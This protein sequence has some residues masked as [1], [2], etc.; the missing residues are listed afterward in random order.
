MARGAP[1][2]VAALLAAMCADAQVAA[3]QW[4]SWR[5]GPQNAGAR[6]CPTPEG[7]V[8]WTADLGAW[9]FATPVIDAHGVVYAGSY[10]GEVCALDGATGKRRW[11]IA[12]GAP[13]VG[14]LALANGVV[15]AVSRDGAVHGVGADDG[16]AL[17]KKA[18]DG[19]NIGSPVIG[20][21]GRVY[22]ARHGGLV[23]LEAATGDER[24][25]CAEVSAG[26]AVA[27][28]PDGRA[29]Y[30]R[31]DGVVAI[32]LRSGEVRWR[33]GL[34]GDS[35][36]PPVVSRTGDI[37]VS[38][39]VSSSAS[40][41][42]AVDGRSGRVRWRLPLVGRF[43][44]A[45]LALRADGALI[46]VTNAALPQEQAGWDPAKDLS[47]ENPRGRIRSGGDAE[48]LCVSARSGTVRWRAAV[49]GPVHSGPVVTADGTILFGT[50]L[51]RFLAV[52]G[53]T[54]ERKW[55]VRAGLS[56]DGSPAL[57]ESGAVVFGSYDGKVYRVR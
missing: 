46:V 20:P 1:W 50:A 40:Y 11:T 18:A 28:S 15:I 45:P 5:G 32:D 33:A 24:V 35:Q 49:T 42:A 52:D 57:A 36:S 13:I 12:C 19:E 53:R 54:G 16:T 43:V 30:A 25:I 17:W 56:V 6:A 48:L 37:Y 7:E 3:P 8:H 27:F 47:P 23:R 38:G 14:S 55:T 29:V 26:A 22:L 2:V 31:G 39:S 9:I 51:G 21:D 41:L 44:S 34:P 10:A 4:E